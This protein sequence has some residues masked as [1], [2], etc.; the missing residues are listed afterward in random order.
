M[1]FYYIQDALTGDYVTTDLGTELIVNWEDARRY[2]VGKTE[3]Q[4]K[5]QYELGS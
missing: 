4:M 5:Q 3:E 1:N 2:A